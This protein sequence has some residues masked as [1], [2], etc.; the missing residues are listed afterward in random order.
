MATKRSQRIGIWIIAGA[1]VIGTLGGFAA[2]ILAPKNAAKDQAR[3]EELTKQYQASYTE[4]QKKLDAQ[5]S[6]LSNKYYPVLSQYASVPAAFD[7]ASVKELTTSDLVMGTG[8]EIKE[9]TSY[10]AYYIGWNPS[11]KV[12]DQ[13]IDGTALKAPIAG[14][15]LIEFTS[16]YESAISCPAFLSTSPWTK[17][18]VSTSLAPLRASVRRRLARNRSYGDGRTAVNGRAGNVGSMMSYPESLPTSSTISSNMA[19]KIYVISSRV[20]YH[21]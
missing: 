7:A 2:L 15:N 13:S 10:S 12:F 17:L 21:F 9:G 20:S 4:Y 5:N 6:E 8:Q 11:G 16:L 1:L 18:Y 14:G 19:S 3:I